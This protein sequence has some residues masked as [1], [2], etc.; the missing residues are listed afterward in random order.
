MF[1]NKTI[2]N[3]KFRAMRLSHP[4][5]IRKIRFFNLYLVNKYCITYFLASNNLDPLTIN[6]NNKSRFQKQILENINFQEN[7]VGCKYYN[8]KKTIF[9]HFYNKLSYDGIT[10]QEQRT[11]TL[12]KRIDMDINNKVFDMTR[13]INIF[14]SIPL[15]A[16]R[17]QTDEN[18]NCS[19]GWKK[20]F[21]FSIK[22]YFRDHHNQQQ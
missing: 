5:K 2:P 12:R 14:Y 7:G 20:R 15:K 13:D 3:F 11:V 1:S 21:C 16:C 9:Q 10:P 22:K 17:N 8:L 19:Q 6:R 4:Q 18:N